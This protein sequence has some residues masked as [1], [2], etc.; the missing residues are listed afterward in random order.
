MKRYC[1]S[2]KLSDKKFSSEICEVF[3]SSMVGPISKTPLTSSV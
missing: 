2:E 3:G 1:D